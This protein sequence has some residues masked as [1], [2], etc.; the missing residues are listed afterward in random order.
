MTHRFFWIASDGWGKQDHLV[1][2]LEEVAQGAITVEL[3]S[4]HIPAFDR[5]MASLTPFNN[6]RNPWFRE[7][8]ETLFRCQLDQAAAVPCDRQ[9]RLLPEHG[10]VQESKVQFVI[11]AVYAY[12][13][14]LQSLHRDVCPGRSDV[15]TAMRKFDGGQF[16]K[17]YL[18]NV[19][20]TGEAA[21]LRVSCFSEVVCTQV[22]I[23]QLKYPFQRARM[24]DLYRHQSH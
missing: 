16:Y 19:S 17:T 18:L 6:V 24:S 14:A 21:E 4:E 2:G 1:Q 5:Y 7:Y 15:C 3:T 8:W 23:Y 10:F 20:F 22:Y 13:H 12:A 9:L 11:D